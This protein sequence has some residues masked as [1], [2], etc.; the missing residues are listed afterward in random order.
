MQRKTPNRYASGDP[1]VGRRR[2]ARV[3]A[4]RA[5]WNTHRWRRDAVLFVAGVLRLAQTR[6]WTRT[7]AE[8][9]PESFGGVWYLKSM[10]LRAQG[11]GLLGASG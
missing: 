6:P 9:G 11:Q 2:G 4:M 1:T 10:V 8:V 7:Y 5:M 3:Q